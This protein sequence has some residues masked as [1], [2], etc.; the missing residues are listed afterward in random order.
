MGDTFRGTAIPLTNQRTDRMIL[1][2][3]IT[4]VCAMVVSGFVMAAN[5]YGD[6]DQGPT[7]DV[8]QIVKDCFNPAETAQQ[9]S[10][11]MLD[12]V[13]ESER[14]CLGPY[15]TERGWIRWDGNN[16]P[17]ELPLC[18]TNNTIADWFYLV[19]SY[20]GYDPFGGYIEV[21]Q[22]DVYKG[23]IWIEWTDAGKGDY[24]CCTYNWWNASFYVKQNFCLDSNQY[25]MGYYDGRY[26][27]DKEVCF[28]A[29]TQWTGCGHPSQD[30]TI[31]HSHFQSELSQRVSSSPYKQKPLIPNNTPRSFP[32]PVPYLNSLDASRIR[33]HMLFNNLE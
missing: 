24:L 14:S 26:I 11:G 28:T 29:F 2:I 32:H 16:L 12:F 8:Q 17:S 19:L 9:Q 10:L 7:D 5:I 30:F 3:S 21:W 15:N 31:I 1:I 4:M 6:Q 13:M 33:C 27:P 23:K 20:G 22:K 18:I 25:P